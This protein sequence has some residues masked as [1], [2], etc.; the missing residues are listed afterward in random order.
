[1]KKL[2]VFRV[3]PDVYRRFVAAT[4]GAPNRSELIRGLLS[5]ACESPPSR[6][7]QRGVKPDLQPFSVFMTPEDIAKLGT[8]CEAAEV[9]RN[10]FVEA[11]LSHAAP[12]VCHG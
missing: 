9:S 10:I 8:A 3:S 12:E 5:K 2:K 6:F 11:V 1:M 7:P 4:A